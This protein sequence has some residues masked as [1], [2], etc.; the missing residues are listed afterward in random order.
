MVIK[1]K[2]KKVFLFVM[3]IYILKVIVF[4]ILFE[5]LLLFCFFWLFYDDW[6]SLG[7]D[8]YNNCDW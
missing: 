2:L 3:N 6:G 7:Y 5:C 4:G 1:C 8:F